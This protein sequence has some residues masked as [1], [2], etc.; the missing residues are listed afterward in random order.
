MKALFSFLALIVLGA[1]IVLWQ[2]YQNKPVENA[3]DSSLEEPTFTSLTGRSYQLGLLG[4]TSDLRVRWKSSDELVIEV[5][6]LTALAK[7]VDAGVALV[8]AYGLDSLSI[9]WQLG[10]IV[11]IDRNGNE[12]DVEEIG[13]F[14]SWEM[15]AAFPESCV[16]IDTMTKVPEP[17]AIYQIE[18]E[19]IELAPVRQSLRATAFFFIKYHFQACVARGFSIYC[20]G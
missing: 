14:N 8:C 11:G 6:S 1:I 13:G 5:D 15:P 3:F 19:I 4:Y 16:G 12:Y 18:P 2:T 17:P 20:L 9:E 10:K 7:Y